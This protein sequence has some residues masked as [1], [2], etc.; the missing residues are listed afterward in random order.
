MY[1]FLMSSGAKDSKTDPYHNISY[2]STGLYDLP[3]PVVAK[4]SL[5]DREVWG[6]ALVRTNEIITADIPRGGK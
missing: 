1:Q 6:G 2:P 3:V 4:V 5:T